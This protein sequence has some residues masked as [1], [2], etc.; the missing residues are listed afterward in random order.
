M[1]EKTYG[2]DDCRYLKQ[3]RC[4][5][6]DVDVNDPENSHCDNVRPHTHRNPIS[7]DREWVG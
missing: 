2:C 5:L 6:W 1:G 3:G 7:Q 4:T